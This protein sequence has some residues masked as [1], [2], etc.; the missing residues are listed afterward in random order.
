MA[1]DYTI[2][3]AKKNKFYRAWKAMHRRCYNPS[4]TNYERWGGRG[5]TVCDR[6]HDFDLFYEDM[7]GGYSTGLSLDRIDND[8]G[9]SPTNC[10][11]ATASQQAMNRS[12][13]RYITHNGATKTMIEWSRD[14]EC[15]YST[16]R[17]RFYVLGWDMEKCLMPVTGKRG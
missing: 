3:N 9:Y 4:T 14:A 11:W 12:S 16:F 13:N 2:R 17:Q 15:K 7:A 1:Y 10:R 6:W 5:I 8:R